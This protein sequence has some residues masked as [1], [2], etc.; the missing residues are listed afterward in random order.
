M[1]LKKPPAK[2]V[3][4]PAG[5]ASPAKPAK[6][7][8]AAKPPAATVTMKQLAA[9]LAENHAMPKKDAERI[10]EGLV[11]LFVDHLKAGDRVRIGGFGILEVRHTPARMGRNPSTGEPMQIEARKKVAFRPA[12]ELKEAV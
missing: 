1:A 6:P 7:A 11:G 8:P 2:A 3:A 10:T 12:K 4:Q 5:K 9:Q